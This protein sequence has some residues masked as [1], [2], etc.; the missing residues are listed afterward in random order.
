MIK[1]LDFLHRNKI[2]HMDLKM[3]NFLVFNK[4]DGTRTIKLIDFNSYDNSENGLIENQSYGTFLYAPP[5]CN[6]K[7]SEGYSTFKADIWALGIC[8]YIMITSKLPFTVEDPEVNFEFGYA[9]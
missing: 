8:F 5:E 3:E 9:C 6:S 1:S 4:D 2:S 7:L